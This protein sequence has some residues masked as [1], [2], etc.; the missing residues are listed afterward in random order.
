MFIKGDKTEATG[1]I[2]WYAD[3]LKELEEGERN[4]T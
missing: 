3:K 4:E 1:K 2:E